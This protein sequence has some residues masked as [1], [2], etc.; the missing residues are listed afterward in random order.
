M[1][2]NF[3][4]SENQVAQMNLISSEKVCGQKLAYG[5]LKVHVSESEGQE[6]PDWLGGQQPG[7]RGSDEGVDSHE[8]S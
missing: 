6:K 7:E 1:S 3:L 5:Q 4:K 2:E 8:K